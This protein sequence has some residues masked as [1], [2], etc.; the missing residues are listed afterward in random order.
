MTRGSFRLAG[1]LISPDIHEILNQLVE[2]AK[3]DRLVGLIA[4]P[5]YRGRRYFPITAGWAAEN[6]TF[7]VGIMEVSMFLIAERAIKQS[8]E[9][10]PT[11]NKPIKR[12]NGHEKP[13]IQNNK[14]I[15]KFNIKKIKWIHILKTSKPI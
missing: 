10:D 5:L 11:Q 1:K 12:K 13:N 14:T 7:S 2:E 15:I 9:E 8:V 6:H 3:N 4:I